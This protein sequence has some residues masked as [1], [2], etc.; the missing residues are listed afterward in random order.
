[1]SRS[2]KSISASLMTTGY[3]VPIFFLN[4]YVG[5]AIF[6]DYI[7]RGRFPSVPEIVQVLSP[8]EL[9]NLQSPTGWALKAAPPVAQESDATAIMASHPVPGGTLP[10][11]AMKAIMPLHE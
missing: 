8:D 2:N 4:P 9:F 1:M 3:I 6:L 7:T 5:G 11:S 10:N